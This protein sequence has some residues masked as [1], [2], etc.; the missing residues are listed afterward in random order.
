ML[1]EMEKEMESKVISSLN[2]ISKKLNNLK[3]LLNYKK[4]FF[5]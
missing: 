2:D 5:S 1:N 4:F 3:K